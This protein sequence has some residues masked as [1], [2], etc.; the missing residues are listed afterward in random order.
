MKK[1][2]IELYLCGHK[3]VS[4][5]CAS[6]LSKSLRNERIRGATQTC[7]D[8]F[9]AEENNRKVVASR[10]QFG[11]W[12]SKRSR[13][14]FNELLEGNPVKKEDT[15]AELNQNALLHVFIICKNSFR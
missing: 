14:A 9:V 8:E 13:E 12:I 10:L 4:S 2:V 1:N 11:K 5:V 3:E 7:F 6:L 15:N